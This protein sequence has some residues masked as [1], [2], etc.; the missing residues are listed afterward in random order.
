MSSSVCEETEVNWE[1]ARIQNRQLR[2]HSSIVQQEKKKFNQV[3]DFFQEFKLRLDASIE[4][5]RRGLDEVKAFREGFSYLKDEGNS[6]EN[7]DDDTE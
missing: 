5:G 1:M 3:I 4:A 2:S 7:S 6:I